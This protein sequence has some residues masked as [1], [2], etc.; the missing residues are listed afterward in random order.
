VHVT[1]APALQVPFWHVSLRSQA[2]PSLHVVPFAAV[3]F[4]H[5][6]VAGLHVPAAW[7]WSLAVHVTGFEPAQTPDWQASVCVQALPSLQGV[8]FD[9][10]GFE[11]VPVEG[12]HV[13]AA[14]HASDGAH[15]TVAPGVHTPTWHVSF[16]SHL[17]PSLQLVPSGKR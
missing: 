11:H 4:V 17:F 12:L 15:V 13:P 10:M 14:W 2:L 3:G 9:A 7:H 16:E 6:P 5:A 1:A 8:P